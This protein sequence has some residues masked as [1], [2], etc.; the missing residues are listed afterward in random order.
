[1]IVMAGGV[2][3]AILVAIILQ[4]SLNGTNG[5]GDRK[6]AGVDT[7]EVLVA[8]KDKRLGQSLSGDDLR[9]Q[10]WP[11]DAV[12][13]QAVVRKGDEATGERIS[14]RLVKSLARGEPVNE[15]VV[16]GS[17]DDNI[18]AARMEKGKRGVAIDV[19]AAAMAGGFVA[20]GD[21][22][23]VLLT[24]EM[25]TRG[26]GA[27]LFAT[28]INRYATETV[29]EDARVLATD[30][31]AV[32]EDNK[33]SVARTVTL[34][35]TPK[36]AEAVA[37]ASK[38]GD[39]RLALRP[40]GDRQRSESVKD[41]KVARKF[42][43]EKARRMQKHFKGMTTDVRIAD[44]MRSVNAVKNGGGNRDQVMRIYSGGGVEEV[45]THQ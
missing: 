29:L 26:E 42:M 20:P 13:D 3:V 7:V 27:G 40:V 22:V 16:A 37:L 34:A 19:D 10:D 15:S 21:N 24:Y 35:V 2:V 8:D 36:Q 38:M 9:W 32:K 41:D 12:F 5:N 39:L 14:G 17:A 4:A 43:S 33:A 18:L 6:K 1:M 44:V 11:E 30:Q 31:K 28:L 25:R 23:D 45:S